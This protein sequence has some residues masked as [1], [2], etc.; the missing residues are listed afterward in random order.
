MIEIHSIQYTYPGRQVPA[1]TGVSLRIPEASLV[2]VM[3]T[4]GSGKTTLIRCLNGLLIPQAGMVV[5]DGMV[6]TAMA[7]LREIRRRVGL[8]FQ[9]PH[10]HM[11]SL[12]VE[13][14]VAFGLE[15]LAVESAEIQRRVDEALQVWGFDHH[16][17][18]AP[19]TLSGGELQRLAIASTMVLEPRYLVLDEATSLLSAASRRKV[20]D[21]ALHV[22]RSLGTSVVIVTQY[23][24]EALQTSRLIVLRDGRLVADGPP[25]DV[26]MDER[27]STGLTIPVS[28]QLERL[29]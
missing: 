7:S 14:E 9:N 22:N 20:M 21:A 18:R 19:W 10:H 1:L 3:G 27:M 2:S 8:V 4:N 24:E 12:T 17:Q 29:L 5:I 11:T 16:R 13:R 6:T 25:R 26:L 23:P 28:L 15:N